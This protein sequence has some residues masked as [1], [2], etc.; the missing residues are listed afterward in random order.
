MET[1]RLIRG[2]RDS[3]LSWQKVADA[4]TAQNVPTGQGG[5]WHASTVR[6]LYG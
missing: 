6:K 3:G 2:L 4:L 5:K 1:L